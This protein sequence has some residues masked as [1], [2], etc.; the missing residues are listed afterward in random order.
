MRLCCELTSCSF[1]ASLFEIFFSS[2]LI[3]RPFS[4]QFFIIILFKLFRWLLYAGNV[5][6]KRERR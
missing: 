6:P 4:L 3:I 1:S 5:S 2:D